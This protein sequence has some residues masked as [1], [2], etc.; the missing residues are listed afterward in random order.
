MEIS[1]ILKYLNLIFINHHHLMNARTR[2]NSTHLFEY[3]EN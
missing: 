1:E 2:N 3:L